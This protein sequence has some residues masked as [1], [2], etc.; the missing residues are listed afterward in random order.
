MRRNPEKNPRTPDLTK[1]KD[2]TCARE[3]PVHTLRLKQQSLNPKFVLTH[4]KK[5][6]PKT[7][8]PESDPES[9]DTR[10]EARSESSS[11]FSSDSDN[12]KSKNSSARF[13]SSGKS[14][15]S[16]CSSRS[17]TSSLESS[18]FET[19][20]DSR[21]SRDLT[22]ELYDRIFDHIEL[23]ATLCFFRRLSISSPSKLHPARHEPQTSPKE[24]SFQTEGVWILHLQ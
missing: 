1:G 19:S 18:E 14:K 17:H 16:R 13:A 4:S 21:N 7:Y 20:D 3:A 12:G 22:E 9:S 5:L 24:K 23:P 6:K 10:S 8:T 11:S 15:L 2:P